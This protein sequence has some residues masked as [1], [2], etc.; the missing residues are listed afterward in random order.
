MQQ[1]R[2]SV[3]LEQVVSQEGVVVLFDT[4]ALEGSDDYDKTLPIPK[5]IKIISRKVNF[6]ERLLELV[7]QSYPIYITQQVFDEAFKA[8]P[9][10]YNKFRRRANKVSKNI[11]NLGRSIRDVKRLKGSLLH[12]F[13]IYELGQG[14]KQN[15]HMLEQMFPLI[16]GQYRLSDCDFDFLL[17]GAAISLTQIP[18]ILVSN[19]NGICFAYNLIS[20]ILR[21]A[22]DQLKFYNRFSPS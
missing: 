5:K 14:Q 22:P 21:L 9:F 3:S 1:Q 16:Q 8:S 13:Q 2:R 15:Y 11:S 6:L 18:T 7:K 10:N 4:C 20:E 17:S 12:H 19:D